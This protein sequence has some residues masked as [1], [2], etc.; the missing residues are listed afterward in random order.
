[1]SVQ[2]MS[3]QMETKQH[4]SDVRPGVLLEGVRY[5]DVDRLQRYLTLGVLTRET[6][7]EAFGHAMREHA[8]R[9]ALVG[10]DGELTYRELDERTD[11]LAAALLERGLRPL[12]RA[13]FQCGNSQELLLAFLACL[14][15]GVIPICA[16]QAFRKHEIGYLGN[17]SQARLHLVQGDDDRFDDVKFAES[18]QEEIP[19]ME[20]I[21]Q[22]R[23]APRGRAWGLQA[24]IDSMPLARART[25][26]QA[27]THD[28][29]QV[30]VFQLSGGTTGV[31]KIIPRFHNE[32]LYNMRCVAAVQGYTR[33]DV[34]FFPTPFMHNLNM[35]CY[36]GPML[37]QGATI[38][39]CRDL[40]PETLC[41]LV[42][43]YQPTWFGVAGPIFQRILPELLLA[44]TA[45]RAR[46]KFVAPKNSA[47]MERT[48]GSYVCH[49]FGMT[50]GVI[51]YTRADDPSE[52]RASGVGR[53]VSEHDEVKIV[54]PGTEDPVADGE[55]GE[56]LFR[57]PYTIQGYYKSEREDASRFTADGFYRSG[58]LMSSRVIDGKRHY[59]FQGRIKDVVD[60]GGE[61][62][63]AEE[64]ELVLNNHPHVSACAVVGMPDQV[65]GERA[66]AYVVLKQDS[67]GLSLEALRAWLEQAG[68]A[69][70]K[71]PER[72]E[73]IDEM[74]LTASGKL[75]KQALRARILETLRQE[76]SAAA[77]TQD[78]ET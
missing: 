36:F 19:S 29:F 45:T 18:M 11:R 49:I 39:V 33:D 56:A 41:G 66:C 44:D 24:L 60:R 7:A 10:P 71:W 20:F 5:P 53:P 73:L 64:V 42:R 34:L 38:T 31:P 57:G 21:L 3:H 16:L 72:L 70:F 2:I 78:G 23:G 61:K 25:Y 63:N 47:S 67:D 22:A 1:M 74:P 51:M 9:R 50:E 55:T 40:K 75:S 54:V 15:A 37:Q 69:K 35:G 6:L 8:E 62:I 59:F 32:Y 27:V 43:E 48:T 12:D 17:L 30:A 77:V 76:S 14:K 28:P 52:V 58:D 46:R 4:T 68:L 65:Y 26:L 13:M